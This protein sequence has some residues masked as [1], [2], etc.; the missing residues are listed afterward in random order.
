MEQKQ[1]TILHQF[2]SQ[3]RLPNFAIPNRYDL[4]LKTDLSACTF[5][6]AVQITLTI[7]DDTK[8]IVLNALELDIHGVSYSNSNTQVR[9]PTILF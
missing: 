3:P 8:I 7:V 5:S 4:H 9:F 6:G 1:K 2:K